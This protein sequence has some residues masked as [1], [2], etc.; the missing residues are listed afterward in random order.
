[1]AVSRSGT[2]AG[3]IFL[4]T[5]GTKPLATASLPGMK[6]KPARE[7][8]ETTIVF[9]ICANETPLLEPRY[10]VSPVALRDR[11]ATSAESVSSVSPAVADSAVM[12]LSPSEAFNDLEVP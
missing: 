11:Y 8:A 10:R 2:N 12:G 7:F 5:A 9:M 6:D 3:C 4:D 1:M